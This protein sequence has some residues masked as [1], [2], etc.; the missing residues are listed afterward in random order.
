MAKPSENAAQESAPT[1]FVGKLR[2]RC[3]ALLSPIASRIQGWP[4]WLRLAASAL[5]LA[6]LIGVGAATTLVQTE[7][8]APPPA[9]TL[10]DALEHLKHGDVE[11]ARHIA[12]TLNSSKLPYEERGGP[13]YVFGVAAA[14]EARAATYPD[15]R[16]RRYLVA[17]R[18]LD[19]AFRQGFVLA[20]NTDGLVLLGQC[21]HNAGRYAR[22]LPYLTLALKRRPRNASHVHQLLA[23]AYY[24]DTNPQLEPALEHIEAYLADRMLAPPERQAG[25]IEQARILIDAGRTGEAEALLQQIP[26]DTPLAMAVNVLKARLLLVRAEPGGGDEPAEDRAHALLADAVSLLRTPASRDP[27][28]QEAQREAQYL[29]GLCYLRQHDYRAAKDQFSRARSLNQGLPEGIAAGIEEADLERLQGD[30]RAAL[31]LYRQTLHELGDLRDYSNPWVPLDALRERMLAA[32]RHY[33][34]TEKF[35]AALELV[36]ALGSL[37][38]EPRKLQLVADAYRRWGD[39]LMAAAALQDAAQ[40]KET[41]T[42]AREKYHEAASHYYKLARASFATREYPDY[43]W[44]SAECYQLAHDFH[45]TVRVMRRYLEQN[46][47]ERRGDALLGIGEAELALGNL[48]AALVPVRELLRDDPR[49]PLAYRAR[50]VAHQV[51][52][53]LRQ[54]DSARAMLLEN[55]EHESLTPQSIEWRDS[56]FALG[57][58]LYRQG[59]QREAQSRKEGVDSDNEEQRKAGLKELEQAAQ[60]FQEAIV[61]LTEALERYPD[62]PQAAEARYALAEAHRQAAK[63]P[64]KKI[65]SVTIETT[66]AA[67]VRQMNDDLEAARKLYGELIEEL[68]ARQDVAPLSP[69]ERDLLRNCYF[70]QADALYDLGRWEEAIQ[71]YSSA[72]NRYQT[73]PEALEAFVQIASCYRHLDQPAKARGTLEQAKV[74]LRR[75]PADAAFDK[76]T[77][78]SRDEWVTL[79]DFLSTL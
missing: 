71:A 54:Y 78:Y 40:R 19:T 79:L 30:D 46:R 51:Y 73:R 13:A 1:S 60:L 7:E 75:I 26:A 36:D 69:R 10:A 76:T 77:R 63:W 56:L 21:W 15:E 23:S 17:A 45:R 9:P 3:A 39:R 20:T 38:T 27:A 29:L 6:A 68:S 42:T 12:S 55:L 57:K 34:D 31:H 33:V 58:I 59:L 47:P 25:M 11:E 43:L 49:H 66:R 16:R 67:L 5:A 52:L 18:Y 53:E 50:L 35:P 22:A 8:K 70:L 62:A 4:L 64:R 61:R 72:T 41:E 24:R 48:E 2:S 65:G 44:Q 37:F 74:M 14:E 28:S 32:Y